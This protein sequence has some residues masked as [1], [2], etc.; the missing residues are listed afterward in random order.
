MDIKELKEL[1]GL[2]LSVGELAAALSDG[3]GVEDADEALEVAVRAVPGISGAAQALE[4]Y[5]AMTDEQAV[6]LEAFVVADFDIANDSVEAAVEGALGI[7]ISLHKLFPL[8]KKP[9]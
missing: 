9:L 1:V 6:E 7:V 5:K 3:I 4:E 2:G 8:F